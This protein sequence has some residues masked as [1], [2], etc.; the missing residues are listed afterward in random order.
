MTLQRPGFSRMCTDSLTVVVIP[1]LLVHLEEGAADE[2]GEGRTEKMRSSHLT[3][4]A[5]SA[6]LPVVMFYLCRAPQCEVND[7]STVQKTLPLLFIVLLHVSN[8]RR[9][10]LEI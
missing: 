3:G 4:H 5:L 8:P 10:D 9:L 2:L 1:N 6:P 7:K